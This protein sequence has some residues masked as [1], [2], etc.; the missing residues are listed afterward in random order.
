MSLFSD[1]SPSYAFTEIKTFHITDP[2]NI[3]QPETIEGSAIKLIV[4]WKNEETYAFFIDSAAY[5][6]IQDLWRTLDT[7]DIQT[8]FYRLLPLWEPSRESAFSKSGMEDLVSAI[9]TFRFPPSF[10]PNAIDPSDRQQRSKKHVFQNNWDV[11]NDAAVHSEGGCISSGSISGWSMHSSVPVQDCVT[12]LGVFRWRSIERFKNY[13]REVEGN[14]GL[15][16]LEGFATMATNESQLEFAQMY[17]FKQGW[18]GSVTKTEKR[19]ENALFNQM[20]FMFG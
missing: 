3:E 15:G 11:F 10:D 2:A 14:A 12:F 19:K 16:S 20:R 5:K 4:D 17:C 13:L 7:C 9:L 18:L 6:N 1:Y 8:S